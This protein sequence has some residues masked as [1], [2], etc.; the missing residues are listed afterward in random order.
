A[1]RIFLPIVDAHTSRIQAPRIIAAKSDP[2]LDAGPSVAR[3]LPG[4]PF[5]PVCG[6][7]PFAPVGVM[8]APPRSRSA[9]ANDAILSLALLVAAPGHRAAQR[10]PDLVDRDDP[11]QPALVVD[12][13]EG[14]EAAQVLVAEHRFERRLHRDANPGR[15]ALLD[16]PRDG[17]GEAAGL[18]H[19]VGG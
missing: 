10:A 16:Q 5:A 12:G 3:G 9:P 15:V 18:G 14:A 6:A 2:G 19:G 4:G 1:T 13:G 17:G 11:Q 8:T 7:V